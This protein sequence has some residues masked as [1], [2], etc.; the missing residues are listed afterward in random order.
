VSLGHFK[1]ARQNINLSTIKS[2]ASAG[3][4]ESLDFSDV[5]MSPEPPGARAEA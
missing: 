5:S 2:R 4:P 1:E 3:A